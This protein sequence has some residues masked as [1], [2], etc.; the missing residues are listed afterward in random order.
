MGVVTQSSEFIVHDRPVWRDHADFVIAAALGEQDL[1]WRYEQLWARQAGPDLFELCCI[2]WFLYD[3]ALGDVVATTRSG[4]RRYVVSKVV[5]QSGRYVFR[6]SFRGRRIT[7]VAREQVLGALTALG[8][9]L[10]SR[11]AT[12]VGIDC[13]NLAHAQEVADY[14]QAQQHEELLECETGRTA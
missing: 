3:V 14:L 1:P 7:P 13:A 5:Q 4:D 8:A 9:V 12:L 6:A 11:S 10:E 2:P